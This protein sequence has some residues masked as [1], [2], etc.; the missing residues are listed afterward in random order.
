MKPED[1]IPKLVSKKGHNVVVYQQEI[2]SEELKVEANVK[3]ALEKESG[4]SVEVEGVWGS[5][6]HHI[7]DLSYDP[8]EYLPHIYGKFREK[9]QDVKVRPLLETPAKGDLIGPKEK[10]KDISEGEKF[11]P[12]LS[13]FGFKEAPKHDKRSCLKFVGGADKGHERLEAY[14]KKSVGHYNDTRNGLLGSEYSSK[15]SPWL[16]NGSLSCREVF[17]ATQDYIKKSGGNTSTK[18]YIDELFW[19][20]FNR[21]WCMRY[22]NKVFSSYGIYD[23]EYYNW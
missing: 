9:S 4:L 8:H 22:K 23:R 3:K 1:F 17:W 14:M 12:E 18:V 11:M 19:R 5:T 10:S 13:D 20:D 7:D 16:Q 21:Y 2:C 6:L 15:L